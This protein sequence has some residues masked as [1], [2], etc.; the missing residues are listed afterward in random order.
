[1]RPALFG[2]ALLMRLLLYNL[3]MRTKPHPALTLA[4]AW[5][6]CLVPYG[7]AMRASRK[8]QHSEQSSGSSSLTERGGP[9]AS[10]P[11][12]VVRRFQD[13]LDRRDVDAIGKLVAGELVVLENGERNNGWA[14]F[15]DNHLIPEM[16]EPTTPSKWELVH[17][18]V[19]G[20]IAWAYTH[21]TVTSERG[22]VVVWSAFVLEQR[23]S[24]WKIVLL[25]WSVGRPNHGAQ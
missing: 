8:A 23:A 4:L 21:A 11:E 20:E 6:I 2:P 5:A 19:S 10:T 15:R 24:G 25:N 17:L 16:K 7:V 22:A 9:E 14:D 12:Q 13:A 18:K 3:G 1:M